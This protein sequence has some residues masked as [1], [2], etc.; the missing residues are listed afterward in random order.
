MYRAILPTC[1][2]A[3][4]FMSGCATVPLGKQMVSIPEIQTVEGALYAIQLKP[5]KQSSRFFSFFELTIRNKSGSDLIVD[6]IISRYMYNGK[7]MGVF[8]WKGMDPADI[9][10]STTPPDVILPGTLFKR[11]IAPYKRVAYA[12][13]HDKSDSS[14]GIVIRAGPLPKGENG[15]LLV[16]GQGGKI[17]REILSV[18][19]VEAHGKI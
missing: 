13:V 9:K 12:P 15:I 19:L 17:F 2:L 6:W 14:L 3:I 5:L 18:T 8:L 16:F 1:V 11:R 7:P 4:I 10:K